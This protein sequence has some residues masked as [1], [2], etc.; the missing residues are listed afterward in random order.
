MG[1]MLLSLKNLQC[2]K[3]QYTRWIYLKPANSTVSKLL[4]SKF[5]VHNDTK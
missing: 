3:N 4:L 1:E 5:S 2:I